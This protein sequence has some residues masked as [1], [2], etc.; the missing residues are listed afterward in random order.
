MTYKG[1]IPNKSGLLSTR[2]YSNSPRE[3]LRGI[4]YNEDRA[5][6]ALERLM[7][8]MAVLER[9]EILSKRE[10]QVL[11]S[12]A[13]SGRFKAVAQELH[14]TLATVKSHMLH[15]R[16]KLNARNSTHAVAIGIRRRLIT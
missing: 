1:Q 9:T 12:F 10:I 16:Y 6:G 3:W 5:I 11:Q 4:R 2:D 8:N 13:H 7:I 14:I 15:I